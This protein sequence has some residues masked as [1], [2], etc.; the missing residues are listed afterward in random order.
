[1]CIQQSMIISYPLAIGS[2]KK[3]SRFMNEK[4]INV[5]SL[6]KKWGCTASCTTAQTHVYISHD[7]PAN[8]RVLK[9]VGWCEIFHCG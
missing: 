6:S 3:G 2:A 4:Q 1:M 9:T 5:C 8:P 7:Q